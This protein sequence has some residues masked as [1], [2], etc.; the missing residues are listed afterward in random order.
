V[1]KITVVPVGDNI[2]IDPETNEVLGPEG[3]LV[4]RDAFWIRRI[5]D[6]VV[7]VEKEKATPAPKSKEA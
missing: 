6:G 1:D 2:V 3:K 5:N 4:V 7:T